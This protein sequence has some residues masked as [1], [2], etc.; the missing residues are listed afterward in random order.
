MAKSLATH[1]SHKSALCLL[2]PA[3]ITPP[4]EAVRKIHDKHF[5]RWPPHINLLYPFLA[6]P[7]EVN[8][9]AEEGAAPHLKEDIRVRIRKA[10]KPFLPFHVSLQAD[11]PGVFSHSSKSKTVWLGPSTQSVQDL[12]AALQAEFAEC[13][14]DQRP[15]SPHLSV[16]QA[17]SDQAAK[18]V[19][20]EIKDSILKFIAEQKEEDAVALDWYVD[21]VF[22]IER[23]GYNGRFKVVGSVE[24]GK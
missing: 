23:K 7:S 16:G 19:G 6:S 14:A 22:V 20:K 1:L 11:P 5:E 9:N 4:V 15:F 12:Q 13:D 3:S 17:R 24:L 2:P 21:Q 10:V 18:A 8:A